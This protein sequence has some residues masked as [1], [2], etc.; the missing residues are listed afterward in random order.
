MYCLL[1]L[2]YPEIS[3]SVYYLFFSIFFSSSFLPYS[4]HNS[5]VETGAEMEI[6]TRLSH[7][8]WAEYDVN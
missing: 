2:F 5:Q 8:D 1:L 3:L 7:L 4:R 6:F